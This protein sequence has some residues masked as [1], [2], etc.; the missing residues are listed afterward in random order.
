MT[1]RDDSV[2]SHATWPRTKTHFRLSLGWREG[3][4]YRHYFVT[5]DGRHITWTC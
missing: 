4:K 2:L 1:V 3:V 5:I